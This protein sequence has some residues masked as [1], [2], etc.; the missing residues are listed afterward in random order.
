MTA[1][2]IENVISE[3]RTPKVN[4]AALLERGTADRIVGWEVD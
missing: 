2:A 4:S 1:S 3:T